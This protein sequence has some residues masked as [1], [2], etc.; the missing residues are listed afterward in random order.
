MDIPVSG[1]AA[2]L[3][4]FLL[5]LGRLREL[6]SAKACVKGQD[7]TALDMTSNCLLV[8][9]RE[10]AQLIQSYL[11]QDLYSLSVTSRKK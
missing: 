6:S 5:L 7:Q 9:E 11:T 8:K 10:Y 2:T 1:T 4:M 3:D